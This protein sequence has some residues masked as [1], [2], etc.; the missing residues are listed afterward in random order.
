M[1][2]PIGIGESLRVDG[3]FEMAWMMMPLVDCEADLCATQAGRSLG[4]TLPYFR[5][6]GKARFFR[7]SQ[8]FYD[9]TAF[10]RVHPLQCECMQ[11]RG[12]WKSDFA[13]LP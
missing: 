10:P 7:Y 9:G 5:E 4:T 6:N 8:P 1:P 13:L 12:G 11:L 2:W 3:T